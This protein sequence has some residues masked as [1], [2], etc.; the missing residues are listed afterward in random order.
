MST[1]Q[2]FLTAWTWNPLVLSITGVGL[3][4]YLFVFRA[5]GRPAW[6]LL[7]LSVFVLT[8][9]SPLN[10]LAN[11]YLFSAHMLQ[12]ILL[13]LVVP[14][15]FILSLPRSVSLAMATALF[16]PS[17]GRL[18][19]WRRRDVG[20]ALADALQRRRR[21]AFGLCL[22]NR[23]AARARDYFFGFRS[24]RRGKKNGSRRL[25]RSSISSAP[26]SPVARSA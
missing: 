13:L 8:L 4:A 17:R 25:G 20:L 5:E 24:S 3:A 15:F 6:L 22:A 9:V 2:F 12:H 18:D 14:A 21:V 10:A 19:R 23:F 26:V 7:A 11:G 1:E 16:R